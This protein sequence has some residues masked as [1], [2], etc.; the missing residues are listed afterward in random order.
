MRRHEELGNDLSESDV[1]ARRDAPVDAQPDLA[2]AAGLA[3]RFATLDGARDG[4]L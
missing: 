2:K 4:S 1:I 3:Y